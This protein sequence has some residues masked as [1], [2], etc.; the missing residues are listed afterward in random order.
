MA[1]Y[2]NFEA[3]FGTEIDHLKHVILQLV[4]VRIFV[5]LFLIIG[6]LRKFWFDDTPKNFVFLD[7]TRL[8]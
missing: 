3:G 6:F 4:N 8:V 2:L 7:K 5:T 1:K